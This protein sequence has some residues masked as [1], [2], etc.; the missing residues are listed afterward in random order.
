MNA[1]AKQVEQLAKMNSKLFKSLLVSQYIMKLSKT[2]NRYCK[3]C[4]KHTP[5]KVSE[6]KK[7]TRGTAH[8]MSYGS[9][10]RP[11]LRGAARGAG[12]HGKY[13]K[14]PG[15]GMYGRKQSKKTDLR[16]QCSVC[17]KSSNQ[18]KGFRTKKLEFK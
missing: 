9:S 13:S 17:K 12:N 1:A 15:G 3:H 11:K 8:P 4:R 18:K 5:H 2:R 14:P 7:R 10:I 6:S 16:F